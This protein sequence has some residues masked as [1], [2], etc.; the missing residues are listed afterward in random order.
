[1][2]QKIWLQT[3]IIDWTEILLDSFERL[4]GYQLISRVG[5]KQE[6]AAALFTTD[7]VV[8]SH[9]IEADPIL[10]YGNQKAL[11]LWGMDWYDF[12]QTPSRLTAEA[13]NRAERSAMLQQVQTQGYIDNYYGVRIASNGQK[14][15]I[16]DTI[17]WNLI[18]SSG[19][20]CGQ[21]ATFAHWQT[22]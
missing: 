20:K 13:V 4:L 19:N 14:F 18:D 7:F 16:A 8:V 6:Q 10:N 2:Y 17:I 15:A 5:N 1:M 12:T 21:A 22:I 9:G 3:H 11:D